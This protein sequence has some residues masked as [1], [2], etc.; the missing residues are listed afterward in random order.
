MNAVETTQEFINGV[1]AAA[2]N[3]QDFTQNAGI[4]DGLVLTVSP[5]G[6]AVCHLFREQ[7]ATL[8]AGS[9]PDE[10]LTLWSGSVR[11]IALIVKNAGSKDANKSA[12]KTTLAR[13]RIWTF[14]LTF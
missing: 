4:D 5:D 8:P 7:V 14:L 2:E 11:K 6:S 3:G 13:L 12:L 10:V 9:T 1:K